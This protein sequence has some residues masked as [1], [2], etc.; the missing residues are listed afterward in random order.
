MGRRKSN[1]ARN[2]DK[3]N[4]VSFL[5][6][7]TR[8]FLECFAALFQI[9]LLRVAAESAAIAECGNYQCRPKKICI[10]KLLIKATKQHEY[11]S[12]PCTQISVDGCIVLE[13]H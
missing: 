1:A 12:F 13:R 10:E 8:I 11:P 9:F 5:Y 4:A 6:H 3:K 2:A 7:D